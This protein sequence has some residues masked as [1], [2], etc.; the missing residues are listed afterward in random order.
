[1]EPVVFHTVGAGGQAMDEMIDHERPF[2][3]VDF[4]AP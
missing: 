2:A 1:M 4:V 3:V